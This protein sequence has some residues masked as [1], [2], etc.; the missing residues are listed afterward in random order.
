[1]MK[2]YF[3]PLIAL[4]FFILTSCS[5]DEV[6]PSQTPTA[7]ECITSKSVSGQIIEGEYI[8]AVEEPSTS[9]GRSAMS[10]SSVLSANGISD[11]TIVRSFK[12]ERSYHV[13]KMKS[14]DAYKLKSDSR[15]RH[16]EPDRRITA[17]GCF[18]VVE[19]RSVTWNIDKVGYSDGSGKT[20][21]I[22]D[23]G[24]DADHPDLNVDKT[25]SKSFMEGKSSFEDDS[26]HGTHI[27]GIIGALNN[28]VGVLGVASG[29]TVVG[30]KVLDE[31]GDGK[32]SGLLA[33]LSYLKSYA[34]A[35][36]VVNISIG[37]PE[38][39]S[40][41]ENEIKSIASRGIY[42]SLAAGNEST[43]ANSYSP[44]RTSGANIYTVS[45]VDSLNTF[46]SF[47]NFGNDV[48]DYAAP[49]VRILSTYRDGKYAILS[50]TSM[51][52]PHVAGILLIN[53]G[54]INSSGN[55]VGDPDGVGDALAHH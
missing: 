12:G 38:V 9:L 37:F 19:P 54:K 27:A 4:A 31:N 14:Q 35:G 2:T 16:I 5:E 8:V 36:D 48:I 6:P 21:W 24:I 53:N 3:L 33:A 40:I 20:A 7:D 45:A 10:I 43:D 23:T 28:N 47:S 32:L 18:T 30:L 34:K 1:M 42:F 44:A 50:G 49:G 55:A 41:L 26:G 25:R 51:A 11:S 29:A 13:V 39:S 15:V 46:A 17:C 52:A 22:I